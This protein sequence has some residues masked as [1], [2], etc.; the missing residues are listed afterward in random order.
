MIKIRIIIIILILFSL[1]LY[2]QGFTPRYYLTGFTPLRFTELDYYKQDKGYSISDHARP[3]LGSH[4]E[5]TAKELD[6]EKRVVKL[7]CKLG[8]IELTKPVFMS[9]DSY[10]LNSFKG[11]FYKTLN[12]KTSELLRNEER[13]D[14]IGLIPEIVIELPKI[15]L[16]KAVR[17]FMGNK[18]GRL[19][20]DGN[21]K[22]TFAGNSSKRSGNALEGSDNKDFDLEMQQDLNLRLKGTIGEKIHVNVNHQQSSDSN[23]MP[24]P[25]EVNINYEGNEDEIVKAIDGGNIS[26]SLSG[27]QFISYSVSSEGLFG[28]KTDLEA[29]NLKVTAIM[30]KDEAKKST[31]KY[32]GSSQADS[33]IFASRDYVKRKMYFIDFPDRLYEIVENSPVPGYSDNQIVRESDG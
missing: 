30:G 26:L 24:T 18:A 23:A 8:N 9:L 15:A 20:L 14:D 19:S 4:L 7:T 21:Q 28:I 29:G 25:T 11:L 31:Q 27:S 22:L 5:T 3:R 12:E 2:G 1:G 32:R 16:P 10:Y 6:Y 33:T 17:R 13:T